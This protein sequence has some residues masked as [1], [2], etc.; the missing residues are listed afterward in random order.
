MKKLFVLFALSLAPLSSHAIGCIG[1]W[2]NQIC[3]EFQERPTDQLTVEITCSRLIGGAVDNSMSVLLL[4]N[5]TAWT[6]VVR[7]YASE[8]GS[9]KQVYNASVPLSPVITR[10]PSGPAP[11]DF[12]TYYGSGLA[13]S[14][15]V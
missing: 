3:P 5:P 8:R 4:S 9:M 6:K 2:P 1:E 13:F 15:R 11:A 7:V 12:H 14:Y 10:D